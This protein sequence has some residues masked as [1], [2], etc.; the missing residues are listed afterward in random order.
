MKSIAMFLILFLTIIAGA[1]NDTS[2]YTRDD[3]SLAGPMGWKPSYSDCLNNHIYDNDMI[4][5]VCLRLGARETKPSFWSLFRLIE[6]YHNAD[7]CIL[8][9]KLPVSTQSGYHWLLIIKSKSKSLLFCNDDYFLSLVDSKISNDDKNESGK[10]LQLTGNAEYY[11]NVLANLKNHKVF[12]NDA[13]N[14]MPIPKGYR[15]SGASYSPFLIYVYDKS[16][17]PKGLS[18]LLGYGFI[19][20]DIINATFDP[21]MLKKQNSNDK[22]MLEY[23]NKAYKQRAI[24]HAALNLIKHAAS[25]QKVEGA[26]KIKVEK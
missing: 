6:K 14:Y 21:A 20:K 12:E 8:I 18:M 9:E 25:G 16:N 24:L 19:D 15:N 10:I 5:E 7:S 17:L 11:E 3:K 26:E 22:K 4:L 2:V 13:S 23:C 1:C